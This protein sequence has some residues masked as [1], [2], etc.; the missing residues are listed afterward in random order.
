MTILICILGY[1]GVLLC[2]VACLGLNSA[3]AGED[4]AG[5]PGLQWGAR[6]GLGLIIAG[7]ILSAGTTKANTT[8][9]TRYSTEELAILADAELPRNTAE[10]LLGALSDDPGVLRRESE[11]TTLALKGEAGDEFTLS[12][13]EAI[14]RVTGNIQFGKGGLRR[15]FTLVKPK[16]KANTPIYLDLIG[17]AI[18][19][20]VGIKITIRF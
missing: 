12:F 20:G 11:R 2:L 15:R 19:G 8:G 4:Q 5:R 9:T 16:N 7:I 18:N 14:S 10:R 13:G 6:L 1:S 3:L 17:P